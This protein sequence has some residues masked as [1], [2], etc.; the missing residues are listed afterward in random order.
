MKFNVMTL[1][2]TAKNYCPRR[3]KN[4]MKKNTYNE[5]IISQ[6]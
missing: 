4:F 3:A 2:F 1:I 5:T 6:Y